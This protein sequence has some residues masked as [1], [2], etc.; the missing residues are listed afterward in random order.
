[1]ATLPAAYDVWGCGHGGTRNMSISPKVHT[2]SVKPAALAGVQ[3]R[4]VL[5]EPLPFVSSGCDR[6]WHKLAWGKQKL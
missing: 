2:W 4:H 1:M 3:G 5:A 6:G